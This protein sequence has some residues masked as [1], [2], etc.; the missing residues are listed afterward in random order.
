MQEELCQFRRNKVLELVLRH[1]DVN[2]ID[3]EWIFRNKS[4]ESGN[5]TRK[6]ERLVAQGYPQI[7]GMD[8]YETLALVD[9]LESIILLLG[10]SCMMKF[11]LYQIDVKSAFLNGNLNEEV[12]VEQPKGFID[13]N[14]AYQVYKLKKTLYGL[15][16]LQEHGMKD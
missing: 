15:N 2:I 16:K 13:P 7:E 3:I 9:R 1:E 5:V 14:F 11:R 10:I 8:F 4:D 12:Y 6:K